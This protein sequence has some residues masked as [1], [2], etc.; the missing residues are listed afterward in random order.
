M[1]PMRLFL[2]QYHRFLLRGLWRLRRGLRRDSSKLKPFLCFM[3]EPFFATCI[4]CQ[5]VIFAAGG[6]VLLHANLTVYDVD[7]TAGDPG[8]GESYPPGDAQH[9]PLRICL[10]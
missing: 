5:G 4:C 3:D 7:P 9:C 6:V 1:S 10:A 2:L 8:A